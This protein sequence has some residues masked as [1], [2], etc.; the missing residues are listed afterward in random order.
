MIGLVLSTF[1]L[2]LWSRLAVLGSGVL[3]TGVGLMQW[4]ARGRWTA[5]R[6][7]ALEEFPRI[8]VDIIREQ[9][10]NIPHETG[11][12]P[13]LWGL[14]IRNVGAAAEF[15]AWADVRTPGTRLSDGRQRR[16]SFAQNRECFLQA[17]TPHGNQ[18]PANYERLMQKEPL[19]S[20][21][22][23]RPP[24]RGSSDQL[25]LRRQCSHPEPAA[26]RVDIACAPGLL[27]CAQSADHI[28]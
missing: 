23:N 1:E 27:L 28:R 5:A 6:R 24:N 11:H 17:R 13:W 4:I 21:A 15:C 12:Q 20:P 9:R 7:G 16:L 25:L 14:E 26:D 8:E 2:P 10:R 3:L 19:A 22:V 18:A